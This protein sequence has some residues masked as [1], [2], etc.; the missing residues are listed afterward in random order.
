MTPAVFSVYADDPALH[1][2]REMAAQK[3]HRVIVNDRD[4]AAVG[5]VTSMD[6]VNALAEGAVFSVADA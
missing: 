1:A 5:I 4:G 6:I 2:V 3:V